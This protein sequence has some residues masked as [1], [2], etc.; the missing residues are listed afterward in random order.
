[1]NKKKTTPMAK[2]LLPL[3]LRQSF[4]GYFDWEKQAWMDGWMDGWMVWMEARS[5][6]GYAV[7][8]A[9]NKL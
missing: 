9:K 3:T 2:R 6:S 4:R 7:G 8:S 1:M 5:W